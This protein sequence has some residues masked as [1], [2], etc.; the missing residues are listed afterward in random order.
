MKTYLI[1]TKFQTYKYVRRVPK[2]LLEYASTATFRVSLGSNVLEATQQALEFNNAI[3]EALQLIS[4]NLADE[5]ILSKLEKLIPMDKEQEQQIT[6]EEQGLFRNV[7]TEYIASQ[8]SNISAEETRD[9]SYFYKEVCPALFRH[10][11]ITD[12]PILRNINYTH[13]LEFRNMITK[14]PKR[15]IHKYRTMEISKILLHLDAVANADRLSPRTAN[16]YVKWLRALFNFA[17]ML[18]HIQVNL[19]NSIPLLKTLDDKLQ[20]LPLDEVELNALLESVPQQMQYL[21]QIL[22]YTGLRLSELYKCTLAEIGGYKCFSLTDRGIKLKTKSSYRVIPIH[23]RLLD[24]MKEFEESRGKVS[25]DNLARTTS[26]TIK[27]LK[28]KDME[29]KS[30]YSLRHRFATQ[31]IQKGADSSIVSELMGHSHNT[32]T[33]SRYSTGFSVR[34]LQEVV[35]ML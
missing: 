17:V 6:K 34:Q 5:L 10:L 33:L 11:G 23:S 30:L 28:F 9:K 35:E 32:M 3:E 7:V 18:N 31:L 16:K 21:L 29:K 4:L 27:K 26:D 14:L 12:N 19:A 2:P 20:R 24:G 22:A 15:N 1:K 25:S 13:L 8:E